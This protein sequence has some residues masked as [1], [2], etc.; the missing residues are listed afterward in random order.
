MAVNTIN[1]ARVSN[2]LQALSILDSLRR[3]TL[4]LFDSAKEYAR[5]GYTL[6]RSAGQGR[7]T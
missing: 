5:D 6:A 2:N 3:N 1:F 7:P 4:A